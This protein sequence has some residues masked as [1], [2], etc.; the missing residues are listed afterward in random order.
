MLQQLSLLYSDWYSCM[1]HLVSS[2]QLMSLHTQRHAVPPPLH[3]TGFFCL[4]EVCVTFISTACHTQHAFNFWL[5]CTVFIIVHVLKLCCIA[6]VWCNLALVHSIS[7]IQ[8]ALDKHHLWLLK[9]G[10]IQLNARCHF[11][12]LKIN[13]FS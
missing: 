10:F 5:V 3:V 12:L 8:L 13:D 11:A 7:R 4:S 9:L 1:A 2:L 6:L